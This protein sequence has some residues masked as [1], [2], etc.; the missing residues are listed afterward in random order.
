MA[1]YALNMIGAVANMIHPL[2]SETELNFMSKKLKV[3]I[4]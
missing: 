2:S 4:F 3:N 1:V